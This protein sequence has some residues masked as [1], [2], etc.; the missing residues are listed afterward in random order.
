MQPE[1]LG[2]ERLPNPYQPRT[3][4]GKTKRMYRFYTG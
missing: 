4:F 2:N 1:R 3:T